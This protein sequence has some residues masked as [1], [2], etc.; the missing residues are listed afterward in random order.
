MLG[1]TL[2]SRFQRNGSTT[3]ATCNATLQRNQQLTFIQSQRTFGVFFK[4]S[5][6]NS[7]ESINNS[8]SRSSSSSR[9]WNYL[10]KRYYSPGSGYHE[11][12][13]SAWKENRFFRYYKFSNKVDGMY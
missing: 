6:A 11:L 12:T 13:Q 1:R 8:S 2:K 4:R 9:V 7:F 10:S 5:S 3:L